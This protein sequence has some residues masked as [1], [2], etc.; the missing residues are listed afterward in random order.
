MFQATYTV[1]EIMFLLA[2]FFICLAVLFHQPISER[3]PMTSTE[4][5]GCEESRATQIAGE[6]DQPK[7]RCADV[8]IS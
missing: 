4:S 8:S 6:N 1:M 3:G 2:G 5:L 7:I